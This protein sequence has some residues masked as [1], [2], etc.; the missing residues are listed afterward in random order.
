MIA[1]G[2]K[3][4]FGGWWNYTKISHQIQLDPGVQIWHQFV[5]FVCLFVVVLLFARY[6]VGFVFKFNVVALGSS[7]FSPFLRWGT[8]C[9][10]ERPY[11]VSLPPVWFWVLGEEF[12]RAQ[13]AVQRKIWVVPRRKMWATGDKTKIDIPTFP[14]S[15]VRAAREKRLRKGMQTSWISLLLRN[16]PESVWMNGRQHEDA[17]D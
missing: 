2:Y 8:P 13:S 3:I 6:G 1:H 4:S 11:C 14:H 9:T 12:L 15:R 7:R 5:V 17:F 16:L 10:Q